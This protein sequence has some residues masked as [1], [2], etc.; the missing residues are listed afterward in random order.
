MYTTDTK[1]TVSSDLNSPLLKSLPA[2]R[3]VPLQPRQGR[4]QGEEIKGANAKT[5]G[6]EDK[7]GQLNSTVPI[8]FGGADAGS[9]KT[10][11]FAQESTI[12]PLPARQDGI[13]KPLLSTQ[14]GTSK[15]LPL[16]A[17]GA[18]S[19]GSKSLLPPVPG[20]D[21]VGTRSLLSAQESPVKTLLEQ[22][23]GSAKTLLS[24][25]AGRGIKHT[26]KTS[27]KPRAGKGK[28]SSVALPRFAYGGARHEV[29][30]TDD[31][32]KSASL[33]VN[34]IGSQA[35]TAKTMGSGAGSANAKTIDSPIKAIES[36][37]K[38]GQLNSTVPI[39]F[40]GADA[41]SAKPLLSAQDGRGIKNTSKT[42]RKPR[43]GKGKDSSV[44]LPRPAYGGAQHEVN[45]T[46]D[47]CKFRQP[48]RWKNQIL[49]KRFLVIM[50]AMMKLEKRMKKEIPKY[51]LEKTVGD[52]AII[53]ARALTG[54]IP[55][56]GAPVT[57]LLNL[58]VTPPLEKRR[59]EW[60][61][62][63][64]KRLRELEENKSISLDDLRNNEGFIDITLQA[65]QVALRTSQVEKREA[66]KNAISKAATPEAP[67][68]SLQQMFISYIDS[69]TIWHIR[70]L[71][72]FSDPKRW[73][74]KNNHRFPEVET[75]GLSYI[76]EQAY[77]ELKGQRN[78]YDQIWKDLYFRGLVNTEG[79]HVGMT[80]HGLMSKRA[81]SIGETFI[82]YISH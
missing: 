6:S 19:M 49:L 66:L 32:Y 21:S 76:L 18:D 56:A 81:S 22:A 52:G 27:R 70:L 39:S 68:L 79:L 63:I 82:V 17:A 47:T 34:T 29:N 62:E 41:G 78:F 73:E 12:K 2:G 11:L 69:F 80:G 5:I 31:A 24:A 46:D 45:S 72:L 42:S 48:G 33:Q 54:I 3:Q 58:I 4:G 67:D 61:E 59:S 9:S 74:E 25:Q 36:E 26:S 77:P 55:V 8:S 30:S 7:G 15:G 13:V 53:V 43:A 38:G 10:L 64:G 57:E 14:D 35:K 75:G 16:P 65:T 60:F 23:A 50:G 20:A 28:N 44:I 1:A 71:D 40:G 51:P 37:D